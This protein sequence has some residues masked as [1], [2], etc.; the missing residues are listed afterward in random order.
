[1]N[2]PWFISLSLLCLLTGVTPSFGQNDATRFQFRFPHAKA[3]YVDAVEVERAETAP[4]PSAALKARLRPGATNLVEL[5]DRLVLQVASAEHLKALIASGRLQLSRSIAPN[6]FILQAADALSAAREADR[7]ARLPQVVACYPVLQRPVDLQGAYAWLPTDSFWGFQWNFE[8][9]NAD[10]SSAGMD[11]NLRAAWPYSIG[12]GVTIAAADTGVEFTHS[13]LAAR[14]A[15]APHYNFATQTTNAAPISTSPSGAHGTEVAGLAVAQLNNGRIA[16]AAPGA[17]LASWVILTTNF[18]LTTDERLMD[19]YQ[20][21]SNV[22]AVQ[23]HSWGNQGVALDGPTLLEQIGISNAITYGR[24]GRG[25]IMVRSCGN[26]RLIGANA[27][28]DGYPSDPRVIAVAAVRYDG[29]VARSS[30]PGAC[31]LLGA[32]S[33]DTASAFNGLLT[34]DLIGNRGVNQI[35][36]CP[37]WD[38]NCP[39]KDLND[40]V[41]D[42]LGFT[43]TSA[44]APQISGIAA[45][46]LSANPN[47][48]YR[49]V[50]QILVLSARHFD[51]ADPD[52]VTNGAGFR[53]SHNDGFG[54]PDAGVAVNLART[55]PLRPPLTNLTFSSSLP[56]AIPDDGLRLVITGPGVPANLTSIQTLPSLGP[57]ADSPTPALP[58]VD[59]G[60][61]TNAGMNLTNKAALIQRQGASDVYAAAIQLAAQSGA[62]FAVVYNSTNSLNEAPLLDT[63]FVPIPAVF[64]NHSN[65][66]ALKNLFQTNAA[67]LAQIRLTNTSYTFTV[68]NTVMCE[69]VA[70]RLM[71]DHPL[72]G[73]LRITLVSPAGT[74]SVLQRYNAD[75]SPGPID[76]T[77]YSTHHFF[78]SSAGTWIAQISDEGSG[79]AGSVLSVALKLSGVSI[80]DTDKDGLDDVWEIIHFA[81]LDET[82]TADPDRDGYSNAREQLMGTD[83]DALGAPVPLDLSRWNQSLARL[84]W[85][86]S[87]NYRYEIWG[88]TNVAALNLLTNVAG[89]WPETE[90]FTPY[91]NPTRQFFRVNA[92]PL[93]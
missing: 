14:V 62:A 37:P 63:D 51:L 68:T 83:P 48:S 1:M 11:L 60:Y 38:P 44:C 23:N 82:P 18:Q 12:T 19:M 77:Y 52:L 90:W 26:D 22:V 69:Q 53:V 59:F 5:T 43:G 55:W 31:V 54:V 81:C 41:F 46:L 36:Y 89:H 27:N 42:A 93:P 17:R 8:R 28:D 79:S 24:A 6:V 91:N 47:L 50:Q 49:D 32:P 21:Q 45:L 7:L 3:L 92:V 29:R 72:R 86:A 80:L 73:D 57:H 65:G 25:V 64:I 61:G 66:I 16:G 85:P 2:N 35:D 4:H 75:L 87:P 67:A 76:W 78:E 33:G 58:L 9:R 88:G 13:E 34:T 74:R 71:T 20:Y 40:Y 56:S 10:G 84:S 39:N 15:G 30:E 70:L